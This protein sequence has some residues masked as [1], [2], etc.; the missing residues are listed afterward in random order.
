MS[1]NSHCD[2]EA[3]SLAQWHDPLQA[4][5]KSSKRSS[6]SWVTLSDMDDEQPYLEPLKVAISTAPVLLGIPTTDHLTAQQVAQSPTSHLDTRT[7]KVDLYEHKLQ[8]P[9]PELKTVHKVGAADG[10]QTMSYSHS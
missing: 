2:F 6:G 10:P 5:R 9:D 7:T 3:S 1:S 8:N 4:A